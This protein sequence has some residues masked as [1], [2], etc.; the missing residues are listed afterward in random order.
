[1]VSSQAT[2]VEALGLME[3]RGI[4]VLP[5][6]NAEGVCRGLVSVFKMNK[7]F[8]PTPNRIFDSRRVS[9]S[10]GNLARTLGAQ[11]LTA[12]DTEVE[13]DLIL[14]ITVMN[15]ESFTR[16]LPKYPPAKLAIIA[17]DRSEVH[18]RDQE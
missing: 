2:V 5:I 7:I 18:H 6:L 4:R 14:M 10:V 15:S 8:C 11:T 13:E 16:R 17:G 9:A 12:R 3:E 1:S